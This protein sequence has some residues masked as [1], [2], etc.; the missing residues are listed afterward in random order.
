MHTFAFHFA[1]LVRKTR[2]KMRKLLMTFLLLLIVW[3]PIASQPI[4]NVR[5]YDE[6]DGLPHS[7]VTQ[8]LQDS[9]GFLWFSTWNG[10]CRFDGYD[11]QTFKTHPG[12]G[13]QMSTD[14]IRDIALLPNGDIL[15]R[16]DEGFY[17]FDTRRCLFRDLTTKELET[18]LN[19]IKQHRQSH[20]IQHNGQFTWRDKHGTI[21]SL[22]G[23]GALSF[24]SD[25]M[26]STPYPLPIS[27]VRP[28]F[29]ALDTEGD[30]WVLGNTGIYKLSTSLRR[31][32]RMALPSSSEVKCLFADSHGRYWV[33][34][35]EDCLVR[36]Y[37]KH[38]DRLLGFLGGDGRLHPSSTPFPSAVY[39]M[40]ESA[41]GTL[42]L[43][44]K[45]DGLYRLV[46]NG[47]RQFAITHVTSLPSPNVYSLVED[48][49][50]RLWA[51]TLGGGICY[52]DSPLV[53]H[54]VFHTPSNYLKD[55]IGQR[56]RY[57]YITH[58]GILLAATTDGLV[59]S[60]LEGDTNRMTFRHHHRE[61][62]RS[63]SLSSSATMDILEEPSGRIL[64]STESGG[65]NVTNPGNLLDEQL[66]FLHLDTSC[67][68]LPSDVT[69]SLTPMGHDRT[70]VVGS[71]LVSI[72]HHDS[73]ARVFDNRY[74]NDNYRFS[75]AH[76]IPLGGD[77]WL[78]GLTDGAFITTTKEMS[79]PAYQPRI[80]LTGA[81]IQGVV[82]N[83]GLEWRDTLTLSPSERS[84]SVHFAAIDYNSPGMVRHAFRLIPSS[85]K[86]DD[87]PWNH[88][89][90]DRTITLLD[91]PPGCYV[92]EIRCTDSDGQWVGNI[93]SLT[94]M[95][96]PTFW[97]STTGR[98][99]ITLIA[100]LILGAIA[101]T[102][103]YIRRIRRHQRETL[104]AYLALLNHPVSNESS[105][106]ELSDK[107]D[108]LEGA[109]ESEEPDLGLYRLSSEDDAMMKRLMAF[110]ET[111]I[112]NS[113][114]RVGDLAAVAATSSSGLQRKLK[115]IMGITPIDLIREVRIK[116][117]CLLLQESSKNVSEVAYACGFSD[118]KYFSR[119]FK[120]SVGVSPSEYKKKG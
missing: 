12:D 78:F 7:H 43:G 87:I 31:T 45:P 94:L 22:T 15:C 34:T 4:C 120:S 117:A 90:T 98:L 56:V 1:L 73:L 58:D 105:S 76:P 106:M 50:G 95:V 63:N 9:H 49:F 100:L 81:T 65:V 103:L 27:I 116:H 32:S 113:D 88:I 2:K 75:D 30:L 39:C 110:I 25:T 64:V 79:R 48:S 68:L 70:L 102:Y 72:L 61:P 37:S 91:L 24:K 77:R 17:L 60:H 38:D 28:S 47:E 44:C 54:P 23:D 57:L 114:L 92:L 29:V 101:A 46:E 107:T 89:G 66:S 8:L 40:Y 82:G 96:T 41:N 93:R 36:A 55:G 86:K 71:H 85:S 21:W 97:E 51:G 111:N 19:L 108:N 11:F 14:R 118:P 62:S 33:C 35:K 6:E 99:L 112:S 84:V 5:F 20:S 52:C 26:P 18:A 74:F 16:V 67:Q 109:E 59:V 3:L 115:Q 53:A 119:C 80:V 69:L 13:C 42:W 10:L 83:W 104:E